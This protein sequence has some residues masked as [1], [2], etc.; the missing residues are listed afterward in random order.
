EA[1]ETQPVAAAS[2]GAGADQIGE[3][4]LALGAPHD[5][6]DVVGSRVIL[7]RAEQ[8]VL[9]IRV[10]EAQGGGVA[11]IEVLLLRLLNLRHGAS[12]DILEPADGLHAAFARRGQNGFE[13]VVVAEIGRAKVLKNGVL[14]VLGMD[15]GVT[16]TLERVGIVFLFAV[17]GQGL[18]GNLPAGDSAAVGERG[19]EDRV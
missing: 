5:A 1:G 16:A 7:Y 17:I 3:G 2:A 10:I 14:V 15:L 8:P 6:V 9:V 11:A 13:H 19:N 4:A 18:S 12:P